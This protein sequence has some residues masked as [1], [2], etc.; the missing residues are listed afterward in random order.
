MSQGP[1]NFNEASKVSKAAS[2]P[3]TTDEVEKAFTECGEQ[4]RAFIR[5]SKP[6]TNEEVRRVRNASKRAT[7]D[8]NGLPRLPLELRLGL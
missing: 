5:E 6:L 8:K 4:L 2:R 3:L 7:L 1:S